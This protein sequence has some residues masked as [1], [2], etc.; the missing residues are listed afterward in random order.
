MSATLAAASPTS[1]SPAAGDLV[2]PL[3]LDPK[4]VGF[5]KREGY[6]YLPGLLTR[7]AAAEA[8]REVLDILRV[9]HALMG[10]QARGKDGAALKLVQTGQ[11]LRGSA[12]DRLVNA[13]A[14]RSIA[15]QLLGGASTLYMPFTA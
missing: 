10:G 3:S 2:R 13:E 9:T 4:E 8:R 5:Y 11:Y 1:S 14:L 12:L 6:L 15:S 7:E